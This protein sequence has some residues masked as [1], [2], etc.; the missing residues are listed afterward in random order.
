MQ[1]D[2]DLPRQIRCI[3][4]VQLHYS[5]LIPL[6][7]GEQKLPSSTLNAYGIALRNSSKHASCA[8]FSSWFGPLSA[9]KIPARLAEGSI[10]EHMLIACSG[11][12]L[13]D[14]LSCSRW[15]IP[16][17]GG[18]PSHWVLGWVDFTSKEVGIFDSIPE[19][20]STSWAKPLLL[21][22]MDTVVKQL[23]RPKIV[24]DR[25]DWT[26][27]VYSPPALQC[28]FDGWSCGIFVMMAMSAVEKGISFEHTGNNLKDD[29][30]ESALKMLLDIPVIRLTPDNKDLDTD[31]SDLVILDGRPEDWHDPNIMDVQSY[32]NQRAVSVSLI[33]D[34]GAPAVAKSGTTGA[35]II[36]KYRQKESSGEKETPE[37]DV[38]TD[39]EANLQ[40]R[41]KAA[42]GSRNNRKSAASRCEALE[43]DQWTHVEV[44]GKQAIT[45]FF[46]RAVKDEPDERPPLKRPKVEDTTSDR[47]FTISKVE[48]PKS[49]ARIF[50]EVQREN[51]LSISHP[52]VTVART[53][54]QVQHSPAEMFACKHL[55]GGQYTEYI[56]RTQTRLLG[57]ISYE[58][59][60]RFCRQLFPY[61]PFPKLKNTANKDHQ[62]FVKQEPNAENGQKRERNTH[63]KEK[64]WTDDE[65]QQLDVSLLAWARWV[66]NFADGFVQSARCEGKTANKDKVCNKCKEL[67]ASD[68]AFKHAVRRKDK[69]AILPIEEQHKLHLA[70]E[71]YAP[72]TLRTTDGRTLQKTLKDPIIFDIFQ[73]LERGSDTESF[74]DLYKAAQ[75]G[76]LKTHSVFK[77]LCDVF[78]DRFRRENSDN[79]NLKYGIRYPETYL[80]FMILMRS[81]GGNSGRQYGILT[82]QLGG[83][84]PRHLRTL[85]AKSADA[86]QNPSLIFENVARVK[87]LADCVEYTGPV[88]IAGDC[89][90]VRAR[91]A[92]SN[93]FGGHIIGSTLALD[94]CQVNEIEDI[95]EII[96]TIK[97][98]KAQATQVRAI[99]VKI[100]LPQFPP[101][102]VALLPTTGTDDAPEIHS[103]LM[104]LLTMASRL[105]LPVISCAADGAA[106]ELSAQA[107]MDSEASHSVPLTY[108]YSMYGIHL[109]AP[110]FE[111]TGPLVSLT[112]PPHARKTCRNQPQHGTHTASLGIG[113][114]VN[115]SLVDLF[116][117]GK[118][119]MVQRDVEDVDKQDDGAARRV[120]HYT[121]LLATTVSDAEDTDKENRTIRNGFEGLFV[122][123]FIFGTLFDAWLSRRAS[124]QD[125]ITSALR[126]RFF[127]HFWRQHIVMLSN[128]YPDL[129]STSRSF[130]SGPSFHIFNRLCDTLVLLSLAYARYYPDQPFCPWLL[131]TEFVEHFFGLARMLLPDFTFAELFKIVQHV[132][133]RQKLLLSGPFKENREKD[134]AV[135]YILDVDTTPLTPDEYQLSKATLSTLELNRL[136]ELS[137]LE[138]SLIC[139]DILRIPVPR[140][141]DQDHPISLSP[142][143]VSKYNT[144]T[145]LPSMESVPATGC[146]FK[147]NIESADLTDSDISEGDTDDD[148]DNN[149]V[150]SSAIDYGMEVPTDIS[151]FAATVARDT[152]RISALCEDLDSTVAEIDDTQATIIHLHAEPT[153]PSAF[154]ISMG[155][156]P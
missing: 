61:K 151:A 63:V 139:K 39:E 99:L 116:R 33:T 88:A 130:I 47:T 107:M 129:Y 34:S 95:D 86:L 83:P 51:V 66:V 30:R 27:C 32:K 156:F 136:V 25:G 112:D 10:E 54:A 29:M 48:M 53:K 125:R 45:A 75:S 103:D 5:D 40:K 110:V 11:L 89:T 154:W 82:S 70:R 71:K 57:G 144:K 133:V 98:H 145:K 69:E 153:V 50:P 132:M 31:E 87:R 42:S 105:N 72:S 26:Y 68:E 77:E 36:E 17:C 18:F 20:H 120:F 22:A 117:T 43:Q 6:I 59:R 21:G 140:V 4:N 111:G 28:Q 81:H 147:G 102:V 148:D 8:I 91:L 2:P 52:K 155:R 94:K 92:Y 24:W 131:G 7:E 35:N 23:A 123:L 128:A 9:G 80:N 62:M 67:A 93:D 90:K 137:Y 150:D 127:L 97:K 56:L 78:A 146:G 58:L 104:N 37:V 16:L 60:A 84:S 15:A 118:S 119:G 65:K 152:A 143:G 55:T 85:V 124:I 14:I 19:L 101:Q 134:S 126:A 46:K 121:A 3:R 96:E 122:Y 106:S 108:D 141:R 149:E 64:D 115:R 41:S 109:R 100:P 12:E 135:G 74:V 138:A 44:K 142:L 1:L 13:K 49:I 113:Y 38:Y 114:L 76:K 73:K 79:P